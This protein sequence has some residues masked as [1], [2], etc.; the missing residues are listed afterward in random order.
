MD[1]NSFIPFEGV[2][3]S[4]QYLSDNLRNLHNFADENSGLL[5]SDIPLDKCFQSQVSVLQKL[6]DAIQEASRQSTADAQEANAIARDALAEAKKANDESEKAN[7]IARAANKTADESV[8]ESKKANETARWANWWSVA[9]L[10]IS[11]GAL[12]VSGIALYLK[13]FL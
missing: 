11:A 6:V 1:K 9:A 12:I 8:L 13:R 2:Q 3:E 7:G 5:H 4:L 10:V